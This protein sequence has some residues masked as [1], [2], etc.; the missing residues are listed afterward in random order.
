MVY[1]ILSRCRDAQISV[2]ALTAGSRAGSSARLFSELA[3]QAFTEPDID[4]DSLQ[5]KEGPGRHE[6]P[7]RGQEA[8]REAGEDVSSTVTLRRPR[9]WSIL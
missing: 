3:M 2:G 8:Q 9:R 7:L 4:C 1:T 6:Y 5:E